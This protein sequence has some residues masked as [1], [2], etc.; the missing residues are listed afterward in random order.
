MVLC[1]TY[2][3]VAYHIMNLFHY[4]KHG[5]KISIYIIAQCFIVQM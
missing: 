4:K 5:I 3:F 1:F 2:C